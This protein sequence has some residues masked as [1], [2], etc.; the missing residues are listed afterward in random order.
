MKLK[1]ILQKIRL[2]I[3]KLLLDKTNHNPVNLPIKKILFLRQDGKIGDY[4]V[5]SFVFRELKKQDPELYIGVTCTKNN[6]YLFENN[7]Y[8]DQ[9]H[10]V[11]KRSIWDRIKCGLN[12]RKFHYDVLIDPTVLLRNRDLLFIR[13]IKASINVGYLKQN[14]QLF[15]INIDDPKLHFAD[16]YKTVLEKIGFTDINTQYDIPFN[17]LA[18]TETIDFIQKNKLER[19]ITLNFFGNGSARQFDDKHIVA[20][21]EYLA[22]KSSLPIVVLTYPTVTEKLKKL[23]AMVNG[24]WSMENNIFFAKIFINENTKSIFHTIELIRYSDL[25]ISP[26]TATIHIAAGLN[27]PIIGFYSQGQQNWLNWHPNNQNRTEIVRYQHNIN[28]ISP[29]Q[30]S[31]EWII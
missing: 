15:N 14:Y 31:P 17:P 28:E 12:L 26:D 10:F 22:K 16:V 19:F 3:G 21:L 2:T 30:I 25:L 23:I 20:I 5:S 13:L 27:K 18:N 6:A 1:T 8:I 9:L 11:Q 7:P 4:I 24:Q 29:E